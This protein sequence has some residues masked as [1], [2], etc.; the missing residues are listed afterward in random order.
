MITRVR[1]L[2]YELCMDGHIHKQHN[3]PTGTKIHVAESGTVIGG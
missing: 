1:D 3:I 2:T